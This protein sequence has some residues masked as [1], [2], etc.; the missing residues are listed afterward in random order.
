MFKENE[1]FSWRAWKAEIAL[2]WMHII[3][4]TKSDNLCY[5]FKNELSRFK[6]R[7]K[8]KLLFFHCPDKIR[9]SAQP[10]ETEKSFSS[11]D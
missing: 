5:K 4:A 6:L 7:N 10:L 1:V 11:V 8:R 9:I 3:R 2:V